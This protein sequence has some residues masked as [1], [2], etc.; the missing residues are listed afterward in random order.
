MTWSALTSLQT[1]ASNDSSDAKDYSPAS[2]AT[3]LTVGWTTIEDA[4]EPRSN[5]GSCVNVFAPGNKI[6]S[7]GIMADTAKGIKKADVRFQHLC[8]LECVH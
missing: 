3:A 2:A 4:R 1:A 5:Y 8:S 6:V 7:C